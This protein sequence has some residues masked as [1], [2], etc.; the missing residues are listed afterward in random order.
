VAAAA[1]ALVSLLVGAAVTASGARRPAKKPAKTT[2][3]TLLERS[4]SATFIDNPP[5][6]AREGDVSQGDMFVFTGR[7][8]RRAGGPQIGRTH[9]VCAITLAAGQRSQ[10]Q[11]TATVGLRGGQ[12]AAQGVTSAGDVLTFAITGGTGRYRTARGTVT[13]R[14]INDQLSKLT[15]HV[16]R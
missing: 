12:I 2:T 9:G 16:I 10:S 5:K 6:A 3:F 14:D 13:S 4:D 1:I 7:L 11:C 15:F 8:S